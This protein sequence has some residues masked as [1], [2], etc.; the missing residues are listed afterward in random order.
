MNKIHDFFLMFFSGI[1]YLMHTFVQNING[2]YHCAMLLLQNCLQTILQSSDTEQRMWRGKK[3]IR[4]W[5]PD[6]QKI[7][8][9]NIQKYEPHD[10]SSEQSKSA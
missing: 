10:Q 7:K 4:M 6:W 8:A 2:I 9:K 1:F 3:S 5:P